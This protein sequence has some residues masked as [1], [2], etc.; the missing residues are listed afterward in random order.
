MARIARTR[1]NE[2]EER[3]LEAV[4]LVGKATSAPLD[5]V[6]TL[7]PAAERLMVELERNIRELDEY[8]DLFVRCVSAANNSNA[9]MELHLGEL[10]ESEEKLRRSQ[11]VLTPSII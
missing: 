1:A 6:R 3:L 4:N 10:E 11:G 9:D 7:A 8:M 2:F 5:L